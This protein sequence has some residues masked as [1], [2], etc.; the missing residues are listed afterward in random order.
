MQTEKCNFAILWLTSKITFDANDFLRK[1]PKAS[2]LLE[3]TVANP[4]NWNDSF[5]SR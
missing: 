2:E 5:S 1:D 4:F 3:E